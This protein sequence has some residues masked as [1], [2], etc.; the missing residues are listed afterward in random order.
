MAG[1][2]AGIGE[3][4]LQKKMAAALAGVKEFEKTLVLLQQMFLDEA[5]NMEEIIQK[6]QDGVRSIMDVLDQEDMTNKTIAT[7]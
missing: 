3:G 5:D 4:E 7:I 2:G 1:G 6:I